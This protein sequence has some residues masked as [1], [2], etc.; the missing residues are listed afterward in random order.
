MESS[1]D[2]I[3][4]YLQNLVISDFMNNSSDRPAKREQIILDL[5]KISETSLIVDTPKE[6]DSENNILVS[7]NDDLKIQLN[8][9]IKPNNEPEPE[10]D[11]ILNTLFFKE[12]EEKTDDIINPY[13]DISGDEIVLILSLGRSG[14]TSLVSLLNLLPNTNICGENYNAILKLLWFYYEL[15]EIKKV[16]PTANNYNTF[17]LNL[18]RSRIK[19][20]IIGM[21]K[22]NKDVNLWG[23]KEVRWL[24]RVSLLNVFRDLFPDVKIVLS[25]RKDIIKQSNS[26]FWKKVP[27]AVDVITRQTKE[28]VDFLN[29]NKF[30]YKT[31]YLEEFYDNDK[32]LSIH[33]YVGKKEHFDARRCKSTLNFLKDSYLRQPYLHIHTFYPAKYKFIHI[34]KTGGSAVELYIKPYDE[35][36]IGFGHD[37]ICSHNENPVVII[38][39]PIDRFLSM[40]YY[41]KYGS[42]TEPYTRDQVWLKKYK[43]FTIK[44]FISLF[45]TKSFKNLYNGFTWDQHFMPASHWLDEESY[46]K[47]TVI[48]YDTN[49]QEKINTLMEYIELPDFKKEKELRRVNV[50][51]KDQIVNL[52]M[53]DI[54]WITRYF[55]ED[56]DLWKK[57]HSSPALFKKVI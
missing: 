9:T 27:D 7:H 12:F 56:M 32:L 14:S 5:T 40:F 28:L 37:N 43:S 8:S 23:F 11:T 22:K 39:Y 45:E 41:W 20:L 35:T 38:R 21:F 13:Y 54:E 50:S 1:L 4:E 34:P 26:A 25:L 15:R 24:E 16:I 31:I 51:R 44:D 10:G 47:T 52:D 42:K 3:E 19:N 55:K 46:S 36:I 53:G 57:L 48:L 30:S 17:N 33:E 6:L 49:L 29:V 2:K 18:M